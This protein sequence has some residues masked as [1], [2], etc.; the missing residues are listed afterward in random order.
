MRTNIEYDAPIDLLDM[1]YW[2]LIEHLKKKYG[3]VEYDYFNEFGQVEPR[4]KKYV[5]YIFNSKKVLLEI[6]H[7][8][9]YY[10]N[11]YKSKKKIEP[12]EY[13]KQWFHKARHLVYCNHLEH[14]ILHLK[15]INENPN[16]FNNTVITNIMVPRIVDYIANP[17]K[18]LFASWDWEHLHG[19]GSM[20]ITGLS[21]I[22]VWINS[23]MYISKYDFELSY[24]AKYGREKYIKKRK[25]HIPVEINLNKNRLVYKSLGF[26]IK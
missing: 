14:L 19:L 25:I 10:D 4:N 18:K 22:L 20:I 13:T 26:D 12:C 17:N 21:Q 5:E 1:D 3:N 23:N 16:K 7:I 6:H 8:T 9:E 2:T 11:I 24:L 15:I